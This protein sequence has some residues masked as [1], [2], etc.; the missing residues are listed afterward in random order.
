MDQEFKIE[1][2]KQQLKT[3]HI[4]KYDSK[5][6]IESLDSKEKYLNEKLKKRSAKI[7]KI[8]ENIK[9]RNERNSME[10]SQNFVFT[11]KQKIFEFFCLEKKIK[12]NEL[13]SLVVEKKFKNSQILAFEQI[14]SEIS[15]SENKDE[16]ES[17]I[18][19]EKTKLEIMDLFFKETK[20]EKNL[21]KDNKNFKSFETKMSLNDDYF[22]KKFKKTQIKIEI[23]EKIKK[24]TQLI[25]K[26]SNKKLLYC[27]QDDNSLKQIYFFPELYVNNLSFVLKESFLQNFLD[28]I[29]NERNLNIEYAHDYSNLYN[30]CLILKDSLNDFFQINRVPKEN[31]KVISNNIQKES[32]FDRKPS[33]KSDKNIFHKNDYL[34]DSNLKQK[35]IYLRLAE[36]VGNSIEN[37]KNKLQVEKKE[38]QKQKEEMLIE[39]KTKGSL[40]LTP[41]S[42]FEKVLEIN[43]LKV[44]HL[45]E[46]I[47]KL[48]DDKKK[49][50]E[51]LKKL[52]KL[53]KKEE[54]EIFKLY[55]AQ[56]QKK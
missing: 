27:P 46:K 6:L 49:E 41:L 1:V 5:K 39:M 8:N 55:R 53:Y 51:E 24:I 3:L 30:F 43:K 45:E 34:F 29:E 15:V 26:L 33:L 25:Q 42:Y 19:E 23:E 13:M 40:L 52:K 12:M 16:N 17:L 7:A 36:F 21:N 56:L 9:Y 54:K 35:N 38:L 11:L 32:K 20:E 44:K 14:I 18:L 2:S 4:K 31:M 48:K 22:E 47:T 28:I 10:S 37:I 50:E